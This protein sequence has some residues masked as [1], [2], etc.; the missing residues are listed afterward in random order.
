VC[1]EF[2]SGKSTVLNALLGDK[3]LKMGITPT[4]SRIG[5]LRYGDDSESS[6]ELL[7]AAERVSV[8]PDPESDER[9]FISVPVPWLRHISLVDTPGTNAVVVGHQQITE[10]FI[11]TADLVLFVT[12]CDRAFTQSEREFL[13]LIRTY[14]KKLVV[15]L[16]KVDLLQDQDEEDDVVSFVSENFRDLLGI[17]PKTFLVSAREAL[18]AKMDSQKSGASVEDSPHWGISRFGA[19]E[20][21][22]LT[23]LGSRER[24]R[25]K[26]GNPL[27]LGQHVCHKFLADSSRR[28]RVLSGDEATIV[29]VRQ[30]IDTWEEST[31]AND[32]E[33]QAARI[34]NV[35]L[36]IK[37]RGNSFLDEELQFGN[38][39]RLL[40]GSR[41]DALRQ[42]FENKVIESSDLR[43]EK[44]VSSAIDWLLGKN[45]R[46]WRDV[47]GQL[48]ARASVSVE[49]IARLEAPEHGNSL[50]AA[51]LKVNQGF[52]VDRTHILDRVVD[53]AK[54]V[55]D[56]AGLGRT[57]TSAMQS[58][59]LARS[60]QN[61]L[62]ATAGVEIG[63]L[64]IGS[65]LTTSLL[66]FTGI[67]AA[68]AIAAVGLGILPYKRRQLKDSLGVKVDEVR[69]EL[70]R[71]LR[72][73]FEDETA[74]AAQRLRAAVEPYENFTMARAAA[75]RQHQQDFQDHDRKLKELEALI[76]RELAPLAREADT[77][78][79]DEDDRRP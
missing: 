1:G 38:L 3:Y 41:E 59:K 51:A 34:D 66:D 18:R 56:D 72:E 44:H 14:R 20:N 55:V 75:L 29:R 60:V 45:Q 53:S 35:L 13:E 58:E 49:D 50:V 24:L 42:S 23:S 19:V 52:D 39:P 15:M 77:E 62:Y 17:E 79:E 33:A 64:G 27:G 2:N 4:T 68:S 69:G 9:E 40:F 71:S 10:H 43:I 32:F 78:D 30:M 12:G 48:Q 63:A 22:I 37:N 73:H 74:A 65:L 76:N 25:I 36:E 57:S 54:S 61:A 67:L 21:Y 7:S 28:S 11:P 16:S 26:L 47:S 31:M 8:A 70:Q 46:L 5:V 6:S